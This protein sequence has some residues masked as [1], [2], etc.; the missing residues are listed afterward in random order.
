[1]GVLAIV[2]RGHE[3]RTVFDLRSAGVASGVLFAERFYNWHRRNLDIGVLRIHW[4]GGRDRRL[5]WN[6]Y[7]RNRERAHVSLFR[8]FYD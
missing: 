3:T 5:D 4:A 8:R 7:R 2:G 6:D 1:V